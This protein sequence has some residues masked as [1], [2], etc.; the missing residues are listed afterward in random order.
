MSLRRLAFTL[1]VVLSVLPGLGASDS[2]QGLERYEAHPTPVGELWAYGTA[3]HEREWVAER[4]ERWIDR[5]EASLGRRPQTPFTTILVPSFEELEGVVTALGGAPPNRDTRGIAFPSRRTIVV[6]TDWVQADVPVH[7][8]SVTVRHELAHL[9][10]HRESSRAP[11]WLDEGIAS[12]LSRGRPPAREEAELS[13]LARSGRLYRAATLEDHFPDGHGATT[14]AYRQSALMVDC[15]VERYGSSV[16]PRLLAAFDA[17][18]STDEALTQTIGMT[19]AELE[20]AFPMWFAARVSF[21][22]SVLTFIADPWMV[23]AL[24]ACVA[25]VTVAIR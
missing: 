10:V 19:L 20:E 21:L 7:P 25:A 18:H 13:L 4:L 1:V 2:L 11:R 5:I 24:L 3:L 23:I 17:G 12:W 16:L 14:L 8:L 9:A 6:R 22:R 15:L